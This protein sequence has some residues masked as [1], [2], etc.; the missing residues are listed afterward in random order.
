[1]NR[2]ERRR[3][4]KQTE[5]T[6]TYVLTQDQID[7]M[8][9]EAM[10]AATRRAFLLFMA[11]PVMVLHDKFGF[12]AIRLGRFMHYALIWY[13]SVHDNETE[14]LEIVK[15]AEEECGIR[16]LDHEGEIR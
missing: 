2:A 3:L 10:L 6:K 13:K 11:I 16:V 4:Q 8:K 5:K 1:M 14:I 9:H 15:V 12:G 7:Q